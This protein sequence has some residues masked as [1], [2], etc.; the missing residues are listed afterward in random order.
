MIEKIE[1]FQC[2]CERCGH[3]FVCLELP[4][5]CPESKCRSRKWRVSKLAE[6]EEKRQKIVL[7]SLREGTAVTSVEWV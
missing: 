1:A 7:K 4:E 2:V 5:K 3:K 6:L